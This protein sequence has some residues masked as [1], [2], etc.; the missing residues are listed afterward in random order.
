MADPRV[1]AFSLSRVAI[2]DGTTGLE[3]TDGRLYTVNSATIELDADSFDNVGDDL[4]R[5]TWNWGN[6]GNLSVQGGYIPFRT[7]SLIYGLTTV[8]SGSGAD[9][10][11]SQ[12]LWERKSMNPVPRPVLIRMPSRDAAGIARN[13][14]II[15]FKVQFAPIT[16]DGPAYKDGLK[17]NYTG[18]AL[19]SDVDEVGDP[20]LDSSGNATDAIGRIVSTNAT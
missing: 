3:E 15:L 11:F 20:V 12:L 9:Q 6:R 4:I 5:S 2:L 14:D 13:L 7:L 19:F 16:F 10:V 17:I 8:S 18:Q 1:E